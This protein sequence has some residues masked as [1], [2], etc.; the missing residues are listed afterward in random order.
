MIP[1]IRIETGT[2]FVTS[3][4]NF[5]ALSNLGQVAKDLRNRSYTGKV[6]F[7][8][9]GL[10]GDSSDRF[11]E[12]DFDGGFDRASFK[13]PES[14]KYREIQDKFLKEHPE[15]LHEETLLSL[16]EI[17]AFLGSKES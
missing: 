17:D 3:S 10:R 5:N 15:F 16:E 1:K 11:V 2:A 12:M 7:D 6:V 13:Y 9:L 4:F 8:M 14:P